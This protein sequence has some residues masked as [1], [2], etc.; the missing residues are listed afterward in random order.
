MLTP[1]HLPG[2]GNPADSVSEGDSA[3]LVAPRTEDTL[4][5][6]PLSQGSPTP[7]FHDV[8]ADLPASTVSAPASTLANINPATSQQISNDHAALSPTITEATKAKGKSIQKITR[9][10][11]SSKEEAIALLKA[12]SL[13]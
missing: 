3:A 1:A 2:Q 6:A 10:G 12:K 8:F 13:M 9:R 4:A 5:A 7:S 11:P